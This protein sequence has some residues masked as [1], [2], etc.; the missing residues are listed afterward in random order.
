[1]GETEVPPTDAYTE[2]RRM[3]DHPNITRETP[4]D[5]DKLKR[6]MVLDRKVLRFYTTW[7]VC[8]TLPLSPTPHGRCVP[9]S[10]YPLDHMAGV[11]HPPTIP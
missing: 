2:T 4:S 7:Q 1:M 6:F 5:F 11:C 10:H 3:K 8:A 9:P